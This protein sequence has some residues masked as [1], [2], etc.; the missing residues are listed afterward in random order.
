MAGDGKTPEQD[1]VI[2]C[3]RTLMLSGYQV[4]QVSLSITHVFVEVKRH[5]VFG[6]P[7]QTGLVLCLSPL[8]SA[9]IRQIEIEARERGL[10]LVFVDQFVEG[11]PSFRYDEFVSKLGGPVTCWLPEIPDLK[12]VLVSLGA[13][14]LP[15]GFEGAPDC[16]FEELVTQTLRFIFANRAVHYGSERLFE[17]LADGVAWCSDR[18]VVL[19]DC[20]ASSGGYEPSADDMRRFVD[21]VTEFQRKYSPFFRV[22][23]FLVVSTTWAVGPDARERRSRELFAACRVPLVWMTSEELAE[24]ARLLVSHQRYRQMI[25][26]ERIL[27][28]PE[29]SSADLR[30]QLE[31]LK[32]D[33]IV[34]VV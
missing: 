24:S 19:Y 6:T 14:Q 10:H 11:R 33:G 22:A 28:S 32:R 13:N 17:K 31:Q 21:Y 27:S 5:D 26:W 29:Y 9:R 34:E 12:E 23:A 1:K 4:Q 7:I 25:A 30:T 2:V 16:L 15:P 20:K 18:S 8:S 3:L